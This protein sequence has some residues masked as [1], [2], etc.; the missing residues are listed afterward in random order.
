MQALIDLTAAHPF[1]VWMALAA[2][3]LALEIMT[4]SGYLLWPAAAAA[5]VAVVSPLHLGAPAE[6]G[7]FAGLTLVGI[8]VARRYWPH[9][10]RPHGPDINDPHPRLVG[11]HGRVAGAFLAGHGR[12]FVDGKEWA[13][14]LDGGGDLAH[15]AEVEITAVLTGAC[16][17]VK[18]A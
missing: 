2:I 16:L 5:L 8:V 4:G 18:A 12:V 3:L 14:E 10:L 13:A 7:V 11:L 9:P 15:G 17:K 1:W 6:I